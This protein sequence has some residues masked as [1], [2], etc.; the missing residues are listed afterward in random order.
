MQAATSPNWGSDRGVVFE[1]SK[2]FISFSNSDRAY[3]EQLSEALVTKSQEVMGNVA[4]A[5]THT[6]T[7]DELREAIQDADAFVVLVSDRSLQS[8]YVRMEIGAAWATRKEILVVVLPNSTKTAIPP[9]LQSAPTYDARHN[10]LARAADYIV[11]NL[12]TI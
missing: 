8:N 5:A 2:I 10:S 9:T 4:F 3:A 6:T 7:R 11:Q 1:M 12:R